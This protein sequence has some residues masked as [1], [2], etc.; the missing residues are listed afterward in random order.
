MLVGHHQAL[1]GQSSHQGIEEQPPHQVAN[2]L[3]YNPQQQCPIHEGDS[4]ENGP[5]YLTRS[6]PYQ[7]LLDGAALGAVYLMDIFPFLAFVD[8]YGM[9]FR[10]CP[11]RDEQIQKTL[12]DLTQRKFRTAYVGITRLKFRYSPFLCALHDCL[13]GERRGLFVVFHILTDVTVRST[14]S[15]VI[16]ILTSNHSRWLGDHGHV[17]FEFLNLSSVLFHSS[18]DFKFSEEVH[19]V[20][21]NQD[22]TMHERPAGKIRVY[23]RFFDFAN[24]RLSLSTFLV[25]I[26]RL[27]RINIY[28]LSVIWAAKVSHFEILCRVYEIV[29]TVELFR[30]F[31]VN[32]KRSGWMSFRKR[33]DNAAIWTSLLSSMPRILPSELEAGVDRLFD[34][35]GS[36]HQTEQRDFA[37]GG[38]DVNIQPIVEVV[39]TVV[40]DAAPARSRR[41]GKR[42]SVVVDAGASHPPKKTKGG[43]WNLEWGL[44][45]WFVISSD[46]FH[47]SGTNVAEAEVDSHIR[48]FALIMTTVTTITPTV[49]PTFVTQEKVIKPTLFGVGSSFAGGTDPITCVF[50]DL[51][52]T[53]RQMSLSVEVRMRAEYNIK[54]KK[55]LKCVVDAQGELLKVREKEIENLKVQLSLREVEAAEAI[56][57][58][59]Q[60]S[61]LETAEKSLRDE[62]NALKERYA[63]F[64]KE[65][66]A[67]DVKVAELETSVVDKEREL[68]NLNA[69]LKKFQNDRMKIVNDKFDKLYTDFVEMALHLKE[70]FYPH[71]LTIIFGRMW[72]F[73][74]GIELAIVKCLNLPE[75]LSAIGTTIGRAIEKGMQ[76][77]LAARISYGKEGRVLTDV[78]AHNP[79]AEADYISEEYVILQ[80]HKRDWR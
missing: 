43:S 35:G 78:G 39:S 17:L 32:S 6:G 19:P 31:Y 38:Q 33:F 60:A 29:P 5:K 72:L 37:R 55:R 9:D 34:E 77:G 58:C 15:T 59:A 21:P 14:C 3:F 61:E 4:P 42:K 52:S 48:S 44:C 36:G 56:R 63:I 65:R 45:R 18:K 75:Y 10:T 12:Q 16:T 54:E 2:W 27:F 20:L 64:E 53:A 67:L 1:T 73:T 11:A 68:T 28:Q 24:F 13:L 25:D 62:V 26:L 71:L 51:T 74:H 76:D 46:S 66:D 23:T 80:T 70:K 40:E 41:L 49:D 47:H 50:S 69:L 22:D 30:C 57:L 79:S 8:A 7:R